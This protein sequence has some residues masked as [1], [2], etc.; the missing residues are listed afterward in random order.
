MSFFQANDLHLHRDEA[1]LRILNRVI[2][3]EKNTHWSK[4]WL[5]IQKGINH[6]SLCPIAYTVFR[7]YRCP[8]FFFTW[9][10][11][12][13]DQCSKE[14]ICG[15][16]SRA[17][18]STK[19]TTGSDG[20]GVQPAEGVCCSTDG[21]YVMN[22]LYCPPLFGGSGVCSSDLSPRNIKHLGWAGSGVSQ[23]HQARECWA[24]E[25]GEL[26]PR[27]TTAWSQ[28]LPQYK[29]SPPSVS[30][31]LWTMVHTHPDQCLFFT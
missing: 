26:T 11:S 2:L 25:G 10:H 8:H 17:P 19:E 18:K 4:T 16:C 28:P 12:L 14:G 3:Q 30:P 29:E 20:C 5:K 7:F 23:I 22:D 9:E 1:S 31:H 6:F 27:D 21:F 13:L 15:P 24:P